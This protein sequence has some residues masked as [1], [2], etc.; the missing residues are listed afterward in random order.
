M[1]EK[2][3]KTVKKNKELEKIQ[4]QINKLDIFVNEMN[5]KITRVLERLGLHKE[6]K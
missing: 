3:K 1:A 4:E 6:F 5:T 2:K